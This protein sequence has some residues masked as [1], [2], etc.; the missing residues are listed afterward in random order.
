MST[1]IPV[2]LSTASVY[3]ERVERGFEY[4]AQAEYDGVEVMVWADSITQD[5]DQVRA[6]SKKYSMPVLAIHAPTLLLT[7]LV[8]GGGPWEKVERSAQMAY[9]LGATTVVVHPPFRWQ[10]GYAEAF[11]DGVRRV[12]EE[13]SVTIA[14]ENMYPW[15][16][17]SRELKAY[18][19]GWDPREFNYDNVT[20]DLSH[21]AT[22]QQNSLEIAQDLGQ[23]LSH[24]HFTDGSGSMKDE[25]LLPGRGNQPCRPLLEHLVSTNF[26]GTVVL[27]INT[28]KAKEPGERLAEV[29]DALS[30]TREGLGQ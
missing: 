15:R 19:P 18:L 25:H 22:A 24:V 7:Q 13:Y 30:F 14:V 17:R 20:L 27:E 4:A 9:D 6:L 1:K 28:R 3:P 29:A 23:R 21:A 10:K 26:E 8:W 16:A 11:E 12:A 5:T 2:A